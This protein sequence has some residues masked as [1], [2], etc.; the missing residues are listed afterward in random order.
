MNKIKLNL[1]TKQDWPV[2]CVQFCFDSIDNADL[3]CNLL[4]GHNADNI[5][6][7]HIVVD[8]T[9][10]IG[11]NAIFVWLLLDTNFNLI[12]KFNLI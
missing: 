8:C 2:E 10:L 1:T 3:H 5:W 6:P 9:V 12:A 7:E 11:N 4:T